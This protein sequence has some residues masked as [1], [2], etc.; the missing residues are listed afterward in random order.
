MRPDWNTYYL[1]IAEAVSARAECTRRKVGA[2]IV[3]DHT[4]VATGYNGAPAG[5]PSCLTGACPRASTNAER[6]SGYAAT[7]CVAIHAEANAIIRAGRDKCLGATMY[8]N[9]TPCE[10]CAPLI[11]AAGITN[12]IYPNAQ[13]TTPDSPRRAEN[14]L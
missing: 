2:V 8:V 7:G 12:V 13:I 6:G 9:H 4:I 5:A 3:R 1:N 10:L 14:G 11:Q